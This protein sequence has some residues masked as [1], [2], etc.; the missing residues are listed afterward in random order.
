MC[1]QSPREFSPHVVVLILNISTS[2]TQSFIV[3]S[4][5]MVVNPL[6]SP[7]RSLFEPVKSSSHRFFPVRS[8]PFQ[9]HCRDLVSPLLPHGLPLSSFPVQYSIAATLP[10]PPRPQPRY[11]EI[12]RLRFPSLSTPGCYFGW[13]LLSFLFTVESAGF[14]TNPLR[15]PMSQPS[16]LVFSRRL[17]VPSLSRRIGQREIGADLNLPVLST[18]W[19]CAPQSSAL[20][21]RN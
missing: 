8:L 9:G 19:T 1:I 11:L 14:F 17:K 13:P 10:M 16:R 3:F 15:M 20:S 6:V 12:L 5:V 21:R 2:H 4:R 18:E 7:P